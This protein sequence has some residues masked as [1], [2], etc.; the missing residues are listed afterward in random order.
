MAILVSDQVPATW[1]LAT[2]GIAAWCRCIAALRGG[3]AVF[4]P[5]VI[6][7]FAM[8]ISL[9]SQ[10][11]ALNASIEELAARSAVLANTLEEAHETEACTALFE[12]ERS[13]RMASR[14]ADRARRALSK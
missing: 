9:D 7:T 14:S 4:S 3:D 8:T 13:L 1:S 2:P 11:S 6:Q 12:V 10:L 5:K